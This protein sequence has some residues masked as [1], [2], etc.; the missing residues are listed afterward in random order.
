MQYQCGTKWYDLYEDTD[1]DSLGLD[2]ENSEI[3][4]QA[5]PNKL[6]KLLACKWLVDASSYIA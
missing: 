5:I 6:G 1:F 3:S 4:V 2:D